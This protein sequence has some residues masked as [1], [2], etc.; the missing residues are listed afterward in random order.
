MINELVENEGEQISPQ[1]VQDFEFIEGSKRAIEKAV[2]EGLLIYVISNQPDV[3]KGWRPL[4]E[5]K[6]GEIDHKL[7]ELGV[8]TVYNCTHGPLND[9]KDKTYTDRNGEIVTCDCRKPQPGLIEACFSKNDL[10]L[11]KSIIVG[12][13]RTDMMAAARF[14]QKMSEHFRKKI[15]LGEYEGLCDKNMKSLKDV[16]EDIV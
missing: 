2:D 8:K 12:D 15:K 14:E 13:S 7:L 4:N 9:R 6:L 16:V 3:S 1:S 10:N 11:Q 5:E